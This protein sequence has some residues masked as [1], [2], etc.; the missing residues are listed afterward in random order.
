MR[1][2]IPQKNHLRE[3]KE[4]GYTLHQLLIKICH[5]HFM[6][7]QPTF[8]IDNLPTEQSTDSGNF[9][10]NIT[11][12]PSRFERLKVMGVAVC[13][14]F[15]SDMTDIG[16]LVQGTTLAALRVANANDTR[17]NHIDYR[18]VSEQEELNPLQDPIARAK[19]AGTA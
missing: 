9:K 3:S 6:N 17:D 8:K 7:S 5:Y 1:N 4:Q 12:L 19:L 15:K 10:P 13:E 16:V 2:T 11:E 14:K 18:S